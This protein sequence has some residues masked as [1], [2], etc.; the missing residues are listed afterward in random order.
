[1]PNL[2]RYIEEARAAGA[3]PIPVTSIVRRA[4]TADGRFKPGSLVPYVEAVNELAAE[5]NIPV[6][7][8]GHTAK[9]CTR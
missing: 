6:V 9:I 7:A 8:R 3:K 2:L 1:M 5:K 4:F